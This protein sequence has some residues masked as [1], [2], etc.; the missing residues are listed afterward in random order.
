MDTNHASLLIILVSLFFSLKSNT[1]FFFDLSQGTF[2]VG[3]GST[4]PT[5]QGTATALSGDNS[6]IVVG[7]KL[8]ANNLGAAWFFTRNATS[9]MDGRKLETK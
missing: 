1:T 7:G 2:L 6:T 9:A 8:D 4:P 5:L 3:T